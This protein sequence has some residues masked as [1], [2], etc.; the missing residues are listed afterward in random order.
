MS[1]DQTLEQREL[2]Q[3]VD[4]IQWYHTLELAPDVVTPGWLDHRAIVGRVPLPATLSGCRCLDVGTFNGFWAFEME[5][6]GAEEVLAVDVLDPRRWDWPV[7]SDEATIR[8][9]GRRM[10]GGDGFEIAAD[11]LGSKVRRLDRSV[12]DLERRE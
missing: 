7:N 10:A 12:Y 3:Q 1:S 2:R 8:E 11:A 4:A 9:I 6:R 5:R